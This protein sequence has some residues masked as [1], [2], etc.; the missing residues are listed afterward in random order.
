M[1]ASCTLHTR[2]NHI[3]EVSIQSVRS[4][5]HTPAAPPPLLAACPAATVPTVS[6][7]TH[8]SV[9]TVHLQQGHCVLGT[10]IGLQCEVTFRSVALTKLASLLAR[11]VTAA[12]TSDISPSLG[13]TTVTTVT[14][15]NTVTTKTT[16]MTVTTVTVV[17]SL[18]SP[19]SLLSLL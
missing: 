17:L 11:K 14:T 2:V 6:L 7:R 16:V 19:L 9:T 4:I 3:S 15:V 5:E 1:H 13:S 10:S 12:A 18:L 8:G